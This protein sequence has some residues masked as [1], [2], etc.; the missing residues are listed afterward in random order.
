[1][2]PRAPRPRS[3]FDLSL[4]IA[5]LMLSVAIALVLCGYLPAAIVAVIAAIFMALSVL[6]D[7]VRMG[8]H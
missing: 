3:V 5:A 4:L 1:M 2:D 6:A 7:L 8:D